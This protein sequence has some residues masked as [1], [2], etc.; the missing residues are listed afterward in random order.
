MRNTLLGLSIPLLLQL[1]DAL[2]KSIYKI[3]GALHTVL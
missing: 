2:P 3:G 1:A